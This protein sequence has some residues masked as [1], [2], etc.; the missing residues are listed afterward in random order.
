MCHGNGKIRSADKSRTP[1]IQ[2]CLF[3]NFSRLW[4]MEHCHVSPEHHGYKGVYFFSPL[5]SME[6]C[7]RSGKIRSADKSK[8]PW[9][10][11]KRVY[12]FSPLWS[13][14]PCVTEAV[15]FVPLTSPGRPPSS[16]L[17]TVNVHN[18]GGR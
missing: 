7:H 18:V 11:Y 1:W 2:G 13:M 15:K 5:W 4:S 9:I 6:R 16:S 17:H 3:I 10:M 14:E 12:F 8:T